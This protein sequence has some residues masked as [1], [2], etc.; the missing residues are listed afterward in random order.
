MNVSV[1]KSL[2]VEI[3]Q[4]LMKH[5]LLIRPEVNRTRWKTQWSKGWDWKFFSYVVYCMQ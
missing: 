3:T 5:F 1:F 2:D 4:K